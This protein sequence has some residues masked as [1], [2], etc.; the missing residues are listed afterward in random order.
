MFR[1]SDT[2]EVVVLGCVLA[3]VLL[4]E[5]IYEDLLKATVLRAFG[6]LVGSSEA[7][8]MAGLTQISLPVVAAVGVVWFLYR[9]LSRQFERE[10]AEIVR[11]RIK[12][13]GTKEHLEFP[14][15]GGTLD[16]QHLT[17]Q[18][19]GKGLLRECMVTVDKITWDN[20][21]GTVEPGVALATVSRAREGLVGRFNLDAGSPKQLLLTSRDLSD[22]RNPG[23]HVIM[24]ERYPVPLFRGKS[25]V[26]YLTA[27]ADEGEPDRISLRFLVDEKYQLS[28]VRAD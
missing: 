13:G 6:Q 5:S 11:P 10:L 7:E 22:I 23:H 2:F 14:S 24:G 19:I 3:L 15:G 26:V 17:V 21:G 25:G 12:L 18:N 20:D 28:F 16:Q 4:F 1:R 9:Y 27:V 8:L